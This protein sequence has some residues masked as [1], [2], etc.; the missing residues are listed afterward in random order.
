MHTQSLRK[1]ASWVIQNKLTKEALFET[2]SERVV[3]ALNT[4]KYEA[5]P[6]LQYLQNLNASIR[7]AQAGQNNRSYA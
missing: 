6:I 2:Y 3:A 4:A 1:T 7:A 5:V